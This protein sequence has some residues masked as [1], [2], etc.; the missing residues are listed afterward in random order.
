MIFLFYFASFEH[1]GC[2]LNRSFAYL[3]VWLDFLPLYFLGV[4]RLLFKRCIPGGSLLL[5]F[6]LYYFN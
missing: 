5:S 6:D 3:L 4:W 2:T 1:A